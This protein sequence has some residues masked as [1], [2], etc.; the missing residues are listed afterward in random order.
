MAK[1]IGLA[2]PSGS[3]K[4]TSFRNLLPEETFIITPT[5]TDELNPHDY[6]KVDKKGEN[7]NLYV[8]KDMNKMKKLRDKVATDEHYKHVKYLI[9]EDQT[10]LFNDLTQSPAFRAR[11]K[12]NEAFARWADFGATYANALLKGVENF[13]HDLF[14]IVCFHVEETMTADG[15]KLKLKTPGTLLEREIDIPSYF[16][17]FLYTKV[18]PVDRTDP[19]PPQERYKFVTNDDGH[20]PAKTKFGAFDELYIPNDMMQV[21]NRITE[22]DAPQT[23]V[24]Q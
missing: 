3:G 8:T 20:T 22:L 6:K 5:K 9:L 17:Y 2:G 7:G 16:T 13:R 4:S 14:I 24:E 18:I 1:L 21:V 11:N 23:K 12:G 15:P 10:H 19:Q